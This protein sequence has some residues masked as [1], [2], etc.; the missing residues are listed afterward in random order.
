MTQKATLNVHL[1]MTT[2]VSLPTT[3]SVRFWE[4]SLKTFDM[5]LEHN[6]GHW[7]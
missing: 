4:A 2:P 7:W 1:S 6:D 5:D 3:F